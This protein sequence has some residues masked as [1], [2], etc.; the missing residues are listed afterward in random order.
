M[1]PCEHVTVAS[2]EGAESGDHSERK[3]M[4]PTEQENHTNNTEDTTTKSTPVTEENHNESTED[5]ACTARDT[6]SNTLTTCVPEDCINSHDV[7]DDADV[8][9]PV[10][11]ADETTP[12]NIPYL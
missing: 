9:T 3:L 6:T 7:N 4:L 1:L 11:V 2:S 10:P 8:L 12:S 5:E